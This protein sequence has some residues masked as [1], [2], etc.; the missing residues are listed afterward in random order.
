[1]S[2]KFQQI[3]KAINI[4]D[5]HIKSA[6]IKEWIM[7]TVVNDMQ[8]VNIEHTFLIF[9]SLLVP[10][11]LVLISPAPPLWSTQLWG[12]SAFMNTSFKLSLPSCTAMMYTVSVP[13]HQA[14]YQH[15]KE[16][17]SSQHPWIS[18]SPHSYGAHTEPTSS[19]GG[20]GKTHSA[21]TVPYPQLLPQPAAMHSSQSHFTYHQFD[22][23]VIKSV[24]LVRDIGK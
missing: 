23:T 21:G 8:M 18:L 10:A 20:P 3:L 11:P 17:L 12:L 6:Q 14:H 24:W 19:H 15:F 4:R 9:R 16:E 22:Y 1:M 2:A 5:M 7:W 13:G